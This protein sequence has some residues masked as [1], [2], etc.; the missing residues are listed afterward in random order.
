MSVLFAACNVSKQYGGLY[1]FT[2][3]SF[4]IKNGIG[5]STLARMVVGLISN[6]KGVIERKEGIKYSYVPQS[7]RVNNALPINV[8]DLI[9]IILGA[10]VD[11][12]NKLISGIIES[13]SVEYLLL[14]QINTLSQGQLQRVLIASSLAVGPDLLVLDEPLQGLDCHSISILYKML[15]DITQNRRTAILIIS[16]HIMGFRYLSDKFL[17][18]SED[19]LQIYDGDQYFNTFNLC[20]YCCM[21]KEH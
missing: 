21:Y 20:S 14:C 4:D 13:A 6:D 12:K 7:F 11:E 8:K 16:H 3:I 19:G 1:V 10:K 9:E 2:N 17:H 5:K 18:L 15:K